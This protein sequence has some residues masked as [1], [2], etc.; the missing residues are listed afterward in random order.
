MGGQLDGLGVGDPAGVGDGDPE[1]AGAGDGLAAVGEGDEDG[2]VTTQE[3]RWARAELSIGVQDAKRVRRT[4]GV[5][6]GITGL[7][8]LAVGATATVDLRRLQTPRG[9]ALAWTEAAVFGDC[10]AFLALSLVEDP[11]AERRNDDE[12]CRDLRKAS[13]AARANSTRIELRPR[14]VDRRGRGATVTIDVR[15][16]DGTTTVS[17]RLVRRGGD[18][19]VVRRAG[20]CASSSCY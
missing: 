3:Q 8:V 19:L 20:A 10:R 11:T 18:W 12:I 5:V 9:G 16:P 15:G 4:P 14:S 13:E 6:I 17:V 1:S 2:A 7:L